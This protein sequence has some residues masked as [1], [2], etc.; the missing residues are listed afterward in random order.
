MFPIY[1]Q[2][3]HGLAKTHKTIESLIPLEHGIFVVPGAKKCALQALGRRFDGRCTCV[4][5]GGCLL[6]L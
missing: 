6:V 2:A 5:V 4:V 3:V 1:K